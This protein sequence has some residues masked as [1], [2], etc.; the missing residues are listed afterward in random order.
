M[1]SEFERT[2][3]YN[4][5]L[6]EIEE[7]I[8]KCCEGKYSAEHV[9]QAIDV[10]NDVYECRKD[11]DVTIIDLCN[12]AMDALCDGEYLSTRNLDEKTVD[13]VY[14]IFEHVKTCLTSL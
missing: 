2:C 8:T 9:E 14:G 1:M 7:V 11:C 13:V 4:D 12:A 5:M 3:K 6:F 10:M